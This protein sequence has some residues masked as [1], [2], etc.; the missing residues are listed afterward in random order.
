MLN[1]AVIYHM[2]QPYYA[3]LLT[4]ETELPWVRLH[5]VKDY[6]DM[7]EILKA[8][9][10][11]HQTFNLVPSLVEQLED[12][13]S[14]SVKDKFLELSYKPAAQLTKQD[15]EFILN[16]FFSINK[17]SVI[18]FHPRYYELFFKKQS[19]KEFNEQDFRDLQ[20][21]FNLA[22]VDPTFRQRH[23]ELT[24][25]MAKARFFTEEDKHVLLDKHLLILEEIIP[26]YKRCMQSGQIEVTMSPFYHPI[27]PL[28]VN[29]KIAREAEL[30]TTLP[31][32]HFAYPQDALAQVNYAAEFFK[33]RFGTDL[34]GMWPSE[35]SVSEH[36]VPY[37]LQA[38]IKWIVTD[39]ALL[40]KSL[41]KKKRDTRLLY[42]PHLIQREEG[43]MAVVFRD[44]NLS[45]LIGFNYNKWKAKDAA[46]DFIKHLENINKA[47]KGQ[48][49]L[50]TVAMDGENAWEYFL[51]DGHEFLNALYQGLSDAS[52]VQC[53]TVSEYLK[54]HAVT[55]A[56][57]RLAAGSWIYGNFGKWIGNP[58]KVK[59]WE[60]LASAR[61]TFDQHLNDPALLQKLGDRLGI[62]WKQM[63]I[64]EGSDWFWWYGEDPDG[65]FDRL[66]RMHLT[67]FYN[68]LGEKPP[69][70]LQRP[71]AP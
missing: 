24:Q 50:V 61:Q 26:G 29:T 40:F 10:K 71:L 27:L 51:H 36:V 56:I 57:P 35:E 9:P 62:A 1:L 11:I 20:V 44:R 42:Q 30:R 7:V 19:K 38:G 21:W 70:Y 47:F 12:L 59:A 66:Y 32:N 55:H 60:W 22:W 25:L 2:H 5:G 58:H 64:L 33:K 67:N 46:L 63:Y 45:D 37:F 28:L 49:L 8:Y 14:R 53:V 16:N 52:F 17:D 23:P 69:E 18:A 31:K 15:Q 41:K 43:S 3:N 65:S 54:T 13:M 34:V 68:L 4:R 39:E 48:D 6:L